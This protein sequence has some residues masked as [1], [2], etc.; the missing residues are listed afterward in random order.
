M[1]L[2]VPEKHRY[3]TTK[4]KEQLLEY[5]LFHDEKS[6]ICADIES[7]HAKVYRSDWK[8][9]G[10]GFCQ[11]E[12]RLYVDDIGLCRE[13]FEEL[14]KQD[15]RIIGHNFKFDQQGLRK[16]G[17]LKDFY[18]NFIDTFIIQNMVDENLHEN[19]IGLKALIKQHY[20]Y[21][22]GN[23]AE[24]SNYN[25]KTGYVNLDTPRFHYYGCDDVYWNLKYWKE[26][27]EPLY[28]E[29][30]FDNLW[31]K[32]VRMGTICVA[33]MEENGMM[34]N[35]Q[36][37]KKRIIK[38]AEIR[39]EVE[40][41]I[42]AMI[43]NDINIGSNVQLK[44]L[45]FEQ[46]GWP[47]EGL[48]MTPKG[49]VSLDDEAL[50]ALHAIYGNRYPALDKIVRW[51]NCNKM[52]GTYL[53][54]NA[55]KALDNGDLRVYPDIYLTSVT[56]RKRCKNPN[57]QNQPNVYADIEINGKVWKKGDLGTRRIFEAKKGFVHVVSD[58]SQAE[59]RLCAHISQDPAMMSAYLDWSCGKCGSS[60]SHKVLLTHCPNCNNEADEAYLKGKNP[61]GFWHGKDIH[62][63]T[64]DAT[65]ISRSNS[66]SV[67]FA[68][69][70]GAS[71]WTMERQFGVYSPDKWS[72]ILDG[73]FR[74]Y[75]GVKRWH[76]WSAEELERT[77]IVYDLFGR[78]RVVT[79]QMK[80]RLGKRALNMFVNMPVQGSGAHYLMVAEAKMRQEFIDKGWW[81]KYVFPLLEV[82]DEVCF[83]V[84]EDLA[85]EASKIIQKH[86]RYAVQLD[87]PMDSDVAIVP[88]WG[89]CK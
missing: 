76:R 82:H 65:G 32:V 56:G 28:L 37:V 31:D 89:L 61:L 34:V 13:I 48:K 7:N 42:R 24:E 72:E 75:Y 71:A 55:E 60:G 81:Y 67:N 1:G 8:L 87:V 80:Q 11:D 36:E 69:I 23:W 40:K 45:F 51:R 29:G 83:E 27:L 2:P 73:F 22:M 30:N 6:D 39:F 57:L 58:L 86:M 52:I 26:K 85:E 68:A 88:S 21:A 18:Y 16:G 74:L 46:W 44:K 43:G 84:K 53:L 62:Q 77:G 33:E 63:M 66:K 20:G 49:N 79:N 54:P 50:T 14:G 64:A 5:I 78:R 59:L 47:T 70:Y 10:V 41:E 25:K 19:Q 15:R 35:L 12:A 38:W 3:F 17:V 4:E 9:H